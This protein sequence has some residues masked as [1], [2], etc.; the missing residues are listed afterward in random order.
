MP[1]ST[2]D[3]GA[4]DEAR[5][6]AG[7]EQRGVR[8]VAPVAHE[9]QGNARLSLAQQGV[10][11]AAGALLGEPRFDHRRV[12]LPGHNGV[13]ADAPAAYCTATTRESWITPALVAA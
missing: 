9:A 7:Q 10:D 13:D 11:V 2:H 5:L 12:Q 1:P 6:V 8:G 4:G 3:L